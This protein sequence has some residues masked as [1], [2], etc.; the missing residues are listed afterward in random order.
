MISNNYFTDDEDLKLFFDEIIDW[1]EIIEESEGLEFF[2][3]KKY[4]ETNDS[5]YEMAPSNIE[6]A[7]ELYKSSLE[8]LGEFFGT[9]VSQASKAMDQNELKYNDG[10]VIFPQETIDIYE[11]FIQTGL[12]GYSISREAGGLE[13]PASL[14]AFF[15]MIM[16]RADV[17]FC[18]TTTLLNLAQIVSRYGTKEQ[19]EKYAAEAA[20]GQRLFAM[21]LTEP[22]FGSDLNSIRTIAT[23]QEDGS[24]RI[25]GTKRFISQGCGLG[26]YPSLL[27]TLARTGKAGGGARGLSVFIVKSEDVVVAGIE[28]KMGIHASPTCEIVYD[29]TPAEILG[30][31]GLGLTRYTAGMTNFMRL[32]SAAGGPGGSAGVYY[33]CFKYANE[34]IQ[35]GKP[36]IEIPAVAELLDK[37]KREMNAM[38]LFVLET[39]RVIDK[40]QHHQIRLEKEGLDDSRIR[41]DER[42]KFWST[43][44]STLT[45]L[46]KYYGSEEGHKCAS[47]GVQIYGGAGYTEDYEVSRMFRD[48]RINTIYEGTSQIHVRIATGAILAGMSGDGNLR[49]YINSLQANLTSP[50]KYLED[51]YTLL[52]ES[53]QVLRS[54][55]ADEVKERLAENLIVQM[56]RYISSLLYERALGK[57]KTQVQLNNWKVECK[58]YVIDSAAIAK[59]CNYRI[60]NFA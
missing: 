45:P 50:S 46:A 12:M 9:E 59:A 4:L 49:K 1:K 14:C 37:I 44:A 22:D 21:A 38:R 15:V 3:H 28:K 52:E 36:I 42:V 48:S 56:V 6:E 27:L 7:Y 10:K 58:N 25:T 60:L 41:K 11:K 23:K 26:E 8:S 13:F 31:E 24:Y 19:I 40:Y 30:E 33:E 32:G 35:F 16:A 17:S 43:I 51:Q 2:A 53:I 57:I 54:I 55:K 29:N 34:R 20:Q 5:R 39:A 18:M 47:I